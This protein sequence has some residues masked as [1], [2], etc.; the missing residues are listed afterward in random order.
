MN[1]YEIWKQKF[2]ERLEYLLKAKGMTQREL[3]EKM[4]I[5][6][7]SISR[8]ASG[9]RIPKATTVINMAA[10]IG[11]PVEMLMKFE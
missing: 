7:V 11:I 2:P 8:Y 3:A 1:T 5:T 4:K 9:Q 10:A 6:E